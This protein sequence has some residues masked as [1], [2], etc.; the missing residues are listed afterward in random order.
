M[1]NL[2]QS[3]ITSVPADLSTLAQIAIIIIIATIL[4]LVIRAFRQPLIPAYI[5]TGIIMGPLVLGLI[6]NQDVV[7]SLS[8]I[9]I[10]FLVF[11][12]GLE[13]KLSKL[14]EVGKTVL[15]TGIIQIVS[16]FAIAFLI[17]EYLKFGNQA[18]M[19]IGLVVTFSSTMI[20]VK[21]LSD[22]REINSLHGRIIMGIMLLQDIAA[23][24]A[25]TI[26]SSDFSLKSFGIMSIKVILFLLATVILSKLANPIFKT[27]AK[28]HD[29]L[30]LVS[31]SFL[32][33]FVLGAFASGL[34]LIIGAFFAGVALANSD[35]KTEIQGKISPLREF[36]AVMFFV[37]LGMQLKVISSEFILLFF[38]LLV[39]VMI[40]K[41]LITMFT[42]RLLGYKKMTSFLTGNALAQTS[43]FSLI[44][45]SL[46]F[47]LG[48]I[49]DN[50]FSTLV[51]LTIVTMSIST[52]LIIHEKRISRIFDWPLNI[53]NGYHSKNEY[54]EYHGNDGKK[55]LIFGCHRMGSLFLREFEKNKGDVFVVDYNPEII[56]S[57]MNKK[58][59]CIYGDYVNEEILNKIN[60]KKAEMMIST[61]PDFEENIFLIKKIKRT[62][63]KII[64]FVVAERISE[65]VSLYK[66]GADYVILPQVIGG[67]KVSEIITRVKNDKSEIQKIKRDHLKYLDSVHHILY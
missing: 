49:N 7:V 40:V 57:L 37:A 27:A 35:F 8:E 42:V 48:Y 18:A 2:L 23:I 52:Y 13:I 3:I 15:I 6:K 55:I 39:L 50:L 29:L 1:F 21:I 36:F 56:K 12:A 20:V 51:L 64:I 65:A 54:L 4:A 34:S 5:A 46:G 61:I 22:K 63:P 38:V 30:L 41:P 17:A 44:I 53:L 59:P 26:L 47:T 33:L 58:I 25:L 19:Y 32:F 31:V 10:A 9:G 16:L 24:I 45:I 67:Q 66:T 62:N 28:T 60:L 14:R 43:E 11:T